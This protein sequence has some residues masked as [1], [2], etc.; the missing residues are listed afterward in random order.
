MLNEASKHLV[1][2]DRTPLPAIGERRFLMVNK[3]RKSSQP[4]GRILFLLFAASLVMLLILS[5]C[6]SQAES[7]SPT[8]DTS[9][10][11]V[12]TDASSGT[13]SPEPEDL[14]L[15]EANVIEVTFEALGNDSYR[16]NVTLQHDDEGEAPH[17]ADWWQVED[18]EGLVLGKRILT[19]SHGNEPFTRSETITIPENISIVIVRGH[20]MNHGFGGQA[21]RVNMTN[22]ELETFM[23]D[24]HSE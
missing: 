23:E 12:A 17:Y 18:L 6:N 3:L 22:G 7:S 14:D 13:Y 2:T 9:P 5:A 21:I 11:Q 24:N 16:F 20:D 19:H 15:R 4:I 10:D 8:A 1:L